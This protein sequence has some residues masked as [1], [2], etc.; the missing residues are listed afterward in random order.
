M[1]DPFTKF[2]DFCKLPDCMFLGDCTT[3][4]ACVYFVNTIQIWNFQKTGIKKRTHNTNGGA[5]RL[6]LSTYLF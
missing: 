6:S 1:S 4:Y 2:S 5:L 3:K